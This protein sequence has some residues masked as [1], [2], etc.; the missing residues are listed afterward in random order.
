MRAS[1]N[2]ESG[3]PARRLLPWFFAGASVLAGKAAMNP[4]RLHAG[5]YLGFFAGASVLATVRARNLSVRPR[6]AGMIASFGLD[7]VS[8][9]VHVLHGMSASL[10]K[11]IPAQRSPCTGRDDRT[12]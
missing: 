1:T 3:S 12:F 10:K 6:T 8:T 11:W 7:P 9:H 5:P 2:D 4:G